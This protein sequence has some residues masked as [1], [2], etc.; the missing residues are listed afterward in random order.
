[1]GGCDLDAH[2]YTPQTDRPAPAIVFFHGG[3]FTSGSPDDFR[4]H[5]EHLAN[6]GMVAISAAYR[7]FAEPLRRSPVLQRQISSRHIAH[8]K[9]DCIDDAVAAIAWTRSRGDVDPSRVAA[10]GYSAGGFL[11]ACASTI[12]RFG[13]NGQPDALVLLSAAPVLNSREGKRVSRDPGLPPTLLLIGS[14]DPFAP[15]ARRLAGAMTENGRVCELVEYDGAHSVFR[16][17]QG[18]EA[19]TDSL[20]RIDGFLVSLAYI[21]DAGR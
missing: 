12:E 14:R 20:A 3:N 11:A 17:Q 2:V 8:T 5:C 9:D 4:F 19:F 15:Q 1:M 6:R 18:N 16:A 7:L 13:D 10:G 21:P